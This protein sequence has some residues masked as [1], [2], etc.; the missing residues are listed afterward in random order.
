MV[1]HVMARGIEG[2]SI[3]RDE[4]DRER[5]LTRLSGEVSKPDGPQ[6]YA[7]AL[8]SNHFHLLLRG[9]EGRLSPMMRRLM[10]GYAVTY[11]N[12]HKR[13]G[14]LFQNRFKSIVVIE[15]LKAE[16]AERLVD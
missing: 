1:Y 10:T 4:D 14:H 9:G 12:R 15:Q 11:N 8:M 6:L 16:R 3:F 2:Q 7:W 5:F 13:Q